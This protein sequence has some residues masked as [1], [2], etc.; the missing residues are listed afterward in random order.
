[1]Q[2]HRRSGWYALGGTLSGLGGAWLVG[3][4]IACLQSSPPHKLDFWIL[5]TPTA[6]GV[7]A[8][9]ILVVLAVMYSPL[10]V[11]SNEYG[12]PGAAGI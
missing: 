2:E 7:A 12:E 10:G 3:Y 9:G 4:G 1:V 8:L 11:P 5:V 6:I